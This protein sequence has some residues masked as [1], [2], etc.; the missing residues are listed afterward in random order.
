MVWLP[1]AGTDCCFRVVIRKFLY[2]NVALALVTQSLERDFVDFLKKVAESTSALRNLTAGDFEGMRNRARRM[3]FMRGG[4]LDLS[5]DKP[6]IHRW[7]TTGSIGIADLFIFDD[8][9]IKIDCPATVTD[10][11]DHKELLEM[12]ETVYRLDWTVVVEVIVKTLRGEQHR[13]I[14]CVFGPR[15]TWK[16]A[17]FSLIIRSALTNVHCPEKIDPFMVSQRWNNTADSAPEKRTAIRDYGRSIFRLIDEAPEQN[18]KTKFCINLPTVKSQ[19]AGTDSL[20]LSMSQF[21]HSIPTRTLPLFVITTNDPVESVFTELPRS[22]DQRDKILVIDTA[23]SALDSSPNNE[24]YDPDRAARMQSFCEECAYK[25]AKYTHQLLSLVCWW[26]S[27]PPERGSIATQMAEC[28]I[29]AYLR[30]RSE[31]DRARQGV[32]DGEERDIFQRL[33]DFIGDPKDPDNDRFV[34]IEGNG[35]LA[36]HTVYQAAGVR[37]DIKRGGK[38]ATKAAKLLDDFMVS[39][40][41]VRNGQLTGGF[42]GYRGI[43]LS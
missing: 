10:F 15:M 13:N 27:D 38:P 33:V 34:R 23:G 16:T 18:S 9:V 30:R 20:L 11:G 32:R 41:G 25:P 26:M 17:V 12:L 1:D 39:K 19:Q 5:G 3:L 22:K 42:P 14:F 29:D 6:K 35:G 24:N 40:F 36:R 21:R 37:A 2:A 43:A 4:A 28:S 8:E 7:G 31:A